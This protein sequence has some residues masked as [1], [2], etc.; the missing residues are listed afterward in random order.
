[1]KTPVEYGRDL[2]LLDSSTLAVHCVQVSDSDLQILHET[3]ANICLCP[4]SNDFI[5]VGRA[6]FEKI[7]A[8][9]INVCL[10]T[11]SLASN[12]DLNLWNELSFFIR[13]I[14]L[15]FSIS[16]AVQLL[17]HNPAQAL[18]MADRLGTLAKGKIWKY[19][20]MPDEV[21]GLFQ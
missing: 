11:D 1:M 5:G 19:A 8:T 2:N 17:S 7:L 15:E 6:P 14:D 4:R 12:Y 20:I 16:E 13:E 10:G 21:V 18:L 3:G 9:E